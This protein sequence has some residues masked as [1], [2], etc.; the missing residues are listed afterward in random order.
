MLDHEGFKKGGEQ[1]RENHGDET[2]GGPLDFEDFP[3][4]DAL[5]NL[6]QARSCS[7]SLCTC[8]IVNI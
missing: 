7:L 6:A 8:L 1:E 3:V 4:S 5:L 2:E